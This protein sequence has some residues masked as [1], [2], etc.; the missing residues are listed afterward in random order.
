[1]QH[2]P[3]AKE[4]QSWHHFFSSK[5]RVT[6]LIFS[7]MLYTLNKINIWETV[8]RSP[9]FRNVFK[10]CFLLHFKTQT[11]QSHIIH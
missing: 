2:S 7:R 8:F 3:Y 11:P 4:K 1:M 9:G 10:I 6:L 5:M